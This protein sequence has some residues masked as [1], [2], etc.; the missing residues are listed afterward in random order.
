MT[1]LRSGRLDLIVGGIF[2]KVRVIDH[3]RPARTG[4]TIGSVQEIDRSMGLAAALAGPV[5]IAQGGFGNRL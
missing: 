5:G 4:S 2:K 3:E 1:I